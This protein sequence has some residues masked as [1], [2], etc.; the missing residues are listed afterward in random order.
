MGYDSRLYIVRKT[1][2]PI[3]DGIYNYAE[4]IAIY[5]MCVFPPFQKLFNE[6]GQLTH[7]C[8]CEGDNY[9]LLDEYGK[10]LREK[11]LDEVIDC[12]EQVI[13]RDDDT[14]HYKR[15]APL[16]ALLK[17]FQGTQDK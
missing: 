9:I 5:K 2:M 11:S 1:D 6:D 13:A 4:T 12:L 14:A 16:L 7:Y 15:V 17:A 8:P 3:G 10:P